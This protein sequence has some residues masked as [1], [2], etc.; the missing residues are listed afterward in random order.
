[1]AR[2]DSEALKYCQYLWAEYEYRHDLVWTRVF[3]FTTAVV[4][5]SVIPYVQKDITRLLGIWILIAPVLA[6]VL[7][8]FVLAVIKNE[9]DLLGTIRVAY[10][11]VQNLLL[12][13]DLQHGLN[14]KSDFEFLV[15]FYLGIL[16]ALSL[17]NG[18]IVYFVWLPRLGAMPVLPLV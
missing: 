9:L 8:G 1:M 18:L 4:L 13:E 11:R 7:A 6:T 10:R 14:K 3:Q 5:I 16:V 15:L 2:I 17:A 12:D